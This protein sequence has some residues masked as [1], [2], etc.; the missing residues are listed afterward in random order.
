MWRGWYINT[1]NIVYCYDKAQQAE[2]WFSEPNSWS[3]D[4]SLFKKKK[5]KFKTTTTKKLY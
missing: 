2:T 5:K 1:K 4:A 3:Q